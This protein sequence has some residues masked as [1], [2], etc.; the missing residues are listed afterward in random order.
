MEIGVQ[1]GSDGS[2][3]G[4]RL[5]YVQLSPTISH[6]SSTGATPHPERTPPSTAE[7]ARYLV[8]LSLGT[9]GLSNSPTNERPT[10]SHPRDDPVLPTTSGPYD[11]F[12]SSTSELNLVWD[13][14]NLPYR[15]FFPPR[16]NPYRWGTTEY[17]SVIHWDEPV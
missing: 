16:E 2:V 6:H 10:S 4:A 14:L 11:I 13:N 9:A 7:L 15:A 8:R 1:E 5:P 17:P 3:T 12:V